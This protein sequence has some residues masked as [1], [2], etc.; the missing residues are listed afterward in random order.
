[1][2]DVLEVPYTPNI[3]DSGPVGKLGHDYTLT[4]KTCLTGDVIGDYSFAKPLLIGD[5]IVFTDMAQYT[6]VKNTTFNGMPLPS[7]G[8]LN[9]DN[10]YHVIK[11]FGYE[12]FW[13][14]V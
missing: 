1:M 14:R 6:M 12:D 9:M 5:K 8:I 4:G 7:I 10:T 3:I 13:R 2:P 11:Q